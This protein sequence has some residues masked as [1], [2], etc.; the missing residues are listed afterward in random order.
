MVYTRTLAGAVWHIQL[1]GHLLC[2]IQ[3]LLVAGQIHTASMTSILSRQTGPCDHRG[4]FLK[5]HQGLCD[6]KFCLAD[7]F[8]KSVPHSAS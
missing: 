3:E 1:H 7:V 2:C 6:V 5:C 4:M 8:I